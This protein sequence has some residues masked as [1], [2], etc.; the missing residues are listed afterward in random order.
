M[1]TKVLDE[2]YIS[3]VSSSNSSAKLGIIM[4]YEIIRTSYNRQF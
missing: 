3:Q 2:A 1:L 4:V